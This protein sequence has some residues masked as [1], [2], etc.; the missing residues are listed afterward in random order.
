MS[1]TSFYLATRLLYQASHSDQIDI[2]SKNTGVV[3]ISL[4]EERTLRFKQIKE[5]NIIFDYSLSNGSL[6]YMTQKVQK[7]W[8]HAIPKDNSIRPRMSMTFR[9]I[10]SDIE[11]K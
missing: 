1:N 4:G 10:K 11:N 8:R 7:D 5:E 6:L 2:L 3:I 9:K